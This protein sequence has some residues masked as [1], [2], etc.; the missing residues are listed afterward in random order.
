MLDLASN[1]IIDRE[2]L[3]LERFKK[4]LYNHTS[5]ICIEAQV[6]T[7]KAVTGGVLLNVTLRG[8]RSS[9]SVV[10][11]QAMLNYSMFVDSVNQGCNIRVF[12]ELLSHTRH[13]E[14]A[15]QAYEIT[16]Y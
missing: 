16:S 3:Q 13:D 2:N 14:P 4:V 11:P 5:C 7:V 9:A 1:N 8:D 12:G 6:K 15:V 10:V